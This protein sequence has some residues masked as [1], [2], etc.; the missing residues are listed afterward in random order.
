LKDQSSIFEKTRFMLEL[1]GYT[2]DF[3]FDL[4]KTG[5]WLKGYTLKGKVSGE[6]KDCKDQVISVELEKQ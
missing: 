1:P 2:P 3:Y 5:S 6:V 4:T